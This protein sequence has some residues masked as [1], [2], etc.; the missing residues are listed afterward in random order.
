MYGRRVQLLIMSFA[1]TGLLS[2]CGPMPPL[3]LAQPALDRP[4]GDDP[5]AQVDPSNQAVV[6]W[7]NHTRARQTALA[8]IV[9]AFN[10]TNPYHITVTQETQGNYE[11]IFRKMIGL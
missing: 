10:Q 7:H 4:K 9:Q 2:I 5:W 11:D 1:L 3:V 8:S 6:F